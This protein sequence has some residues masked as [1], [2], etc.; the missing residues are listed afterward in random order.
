MELTYWEKRFIE[1]GARELKLKS[2][3][4]QL[5]TIRIIKGEEA[6]KEALLSEEPI[7]GCVVHDPR[8]LLHV[9]YP[10]IYK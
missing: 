1:E 8:P 3:Q 9:K 6:Y 10:W 4:R 2:F 5:D 7:I